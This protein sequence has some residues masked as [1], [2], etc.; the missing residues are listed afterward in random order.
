MLCR[1]VKFNGGV[2]ASQLSWLDSILQKSDESSE[3]VLVAGWFLVVV[4]Q[5]YITE[6]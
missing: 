1:F 3:V 2:S 5:I 4:L 6:L